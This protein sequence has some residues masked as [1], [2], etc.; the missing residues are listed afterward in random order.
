MEDSD[1]IK[2][3]FARDEDALA[4]T[5]LKYGGRCQAIAYGVLKNRQDAEEVVSDAYLKLWENIPPD[6]PAVFCAYL[7]KTVRNLALLRYNAE[8]T[9][10][11]RLNKS[12]APLSELDRCLP[13]NSDTESLC[14]GRELSGVINRFLYSLDDDDRGIFVCRYFANMECKEIAKKYGATVSRVKMS[15][16]RSRAKL[17]TVLSKEGYFS[18]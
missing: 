12:A 16:Y 11:W 6:E 10:K 9:D 15:L 18:E 4:Q 13:D 8:M 1:I 5:R 7:Y 2:L 14:E 17:K 3:L